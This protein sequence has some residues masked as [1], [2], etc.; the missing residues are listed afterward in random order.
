[1]ASPQL[2][3][4]SRWT[5][6]ASWIGA[7]AL[8]GAIATTIALLMSG[9]SV[10]LTLAYPAMAIGVSAVLVVTDPARYVALV[11]WLWMVSP[12]VR[13]VVDAQNGWNPQ[14]AILL[15]PLLASTVGALVVM[16]RAGRLQRRV[17][18]PMVLALVALAAGGAVGLTASAPSLVLYA[19]LSWAAPVM[20]GLYVAVHPEH[21]ARMH[22][23]LGAALLVGLTVVGVYG[24]FQFV[25]P[26]LWDR[27]WM[28]NSRMDSI[29]TPQP[30]RV[31]V[32]ST[33]NAPGPL[34]QFLSATVLI[35]LARE[36]A[37]K[38]PAVLAG[39]LGLLLSLA[40]SAWV[41]FAV[42]AI[43]LFLMTRM[44]VRRGMMALG[45]A[46]AVVIALVGT[47]PL[48]PGPDAMRQ[49]ITRRITTMG[50]LSMDDSFRAR[51]Y[52]IPAVMAQIGEHPFGSGLGATL[53]GG[54]RGAAT[55]RLADQGL[56]LDNG[57]LEIFLVLGWFGGVLFLGSA[58]AALLGA[59]RNVRR[60]P[61]AAGYFAAALA[62][63]T[64]V[65]GG[66]IFAGVGGAMFWIA[67]ALASGAAELQRSDGVD[68]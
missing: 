36:G 67:I 60:H 14:N 34:A 43:A 55:S 8:V 2:A 30:F 62:L 9:R 27:L 45:V 12:F 51:R 68:A 32:F 24:I 29:G 18:L 54:A 39:T 26:A 58:A 61:V 7:V 64:Q 59:F 65:L 63:L 40:R 38:W 20:L 53:V 49:T 35:V 66:T 15:A 47:A 42:G 16:Q 23:A 46:S 57:I 44:R 5:I 31:R 19:G 41:G 4:A 52:L 17:A 22:R 3:R 56:Y 33:L 10:L 37:R 48:P 21:H 13:R 6:P 25:Q 50:E 11:A 28:L 1:L